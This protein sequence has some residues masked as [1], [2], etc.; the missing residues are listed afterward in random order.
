MKKREAGFLG[1]AKQNAKR[2]GMVKVPRHLNIRGQK[3]HAI[4][5]TKDE[6]ERLYDA[7]GT[8][9]LTKHGILAFPAYNP[10]G[11]EKTSFGETRQ[12]SAD[13]DGEERLG[14]DSSDNSSH[15]Q[16]PPT[17]KKLEY[18]IGY[19]DKKSLWENIKDININIINPTIEIVIY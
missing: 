5:A 2:K 8:G 10:G 11:E 17:P 3:H 15:N 4:Y 19:N 18:A 16:P 9:E 6:M 1:L 14:G 12:S 13:I 7:G